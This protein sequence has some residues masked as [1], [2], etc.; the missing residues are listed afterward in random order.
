MHNKNNT[1]LNAASW[2]AIALAASLTA[3]LAAPAAAQNASTQDA[4][5]Q[6]AAAVDD[7]IVTATRRSERMQDVGIAVSAY[8]ADKLSDLGVISGRDLVKATPGL[9]FTAPTGGSGTIVFNLRG[10][11]LNDFGVGN[12]GPVAVYVDDVY[13]ASMN[14]GAS[15][16]FDIQQVEVLR[17]PQGT[18]F[19]RNATGGLVH[20]ITTRPYDDFGGKVDLRAGGDS[21]YMEGAVNAPL[22]GG[23]AARLSGVVEQVDPYMKNADGPDGGGIDRSAGRFRLAYS[24]SRFDLDLIA[25]GGHSTS[26]N[27]AT[28]VPT[29]TNAD[30]MGYAVDIPAHQ[31]FGVPNT[32]SLSV[33]DDGDPYT[34]AVN[35]PGHDKRDNFAT[36]LRLRADL[37]DSIEFVSVSDYTRNATNY[38]EDTDVTPL[39][40]AE[41]ASDSRTKQY[42]QEFRLAGTGDRFNWLAGAYYFHNEVWNGRQFNVYVAD[43]AFDSDFN[44]T[45]ESYALFG[46]ASYKLSPTWTVIGGLRWTDERRAI[47]FTQDL[48]FDVDASGLYSPT[49]YVE[50]IFAFSRDLNGDVARQKSSQMS[51][52]ARIEWRPQKGV[53][54]YASYNRGFKSGGF[55][56]PLDASYITPQQMPYE[57]ETLNSYDVGVKTEWMNGRIRANT[58]AFHYDYKD[59]QAFRT[60]GLSSFLSNADAKINGIDVELAARVTQGLDISGGFE[61]LSARAYDIDTPT[62]GKADR[63]LAN[64]PR[65]S[66]N[67]SANYELPLGENAMLFSLSGRYV[68]SQ[69]FDINNSP[70][71]QEDGYGLADARI[72]YR[73][74]DAG[75]ELYVS[76]SNLFDKRYRMYAVDVNALGFSQA[77]YAEPRRITVGVKASW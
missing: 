22:G 5:P 54:A 57:P 74:R 51:G 32:P 23:W 6:D 45:V 1:L 26:R 33:L 68:T 25:R 7:I 62:G 65:F 9:N 52:R 61:V 72:A 18:L 30:G 60:E 64:A 4:S 35:N 36:T 42:S 46:E 40:I 14:S 66:A 55:N 12:E 27:Q 17:G 2:A 50:R 73:L 37:M 70:V 77:M 59:F 48:Y 63:R 44:L 15:P 38:I 8:S 71:A 67:L 47:D 21:S 39:Q 24:G 31:I 16:V 28:F 19:G 29:A 3:G 53:L 41:I 43:A 34:G 69:Y 76:A 20:F 75:P 10:V 56:N 11:G 58:N 49:N 13:Q